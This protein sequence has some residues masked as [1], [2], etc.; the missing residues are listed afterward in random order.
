MRLFIGI[1]LYILNIFLVFL[2]ASMYI[3]TKENLVSLRLETFVPD[4]SFELWDLP[5]ELMAILRPPRKSKAIQADCLALNIFH[6]ARGEGL[7]GMRKVGFVT[8]NRVAAKS[9]PNTICSVVYQP[10]QFSWTLF[11]PRI[12]FSN[13]QEV[14]SFEKAK[15]VSRNIIEGNI[16]DTTHGATH[17]YAHNKIDA[18]S[19]VSRL[20]QVEI[21]GNHTFLR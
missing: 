5:A 10:K 9:W 17:Y 19:W 14:K 16:Q 2:F 1:P 4:G 21:A 11:D 13:P 8:M 7:E 20:E 12:D 15:K 6:E 18:P 3:Q